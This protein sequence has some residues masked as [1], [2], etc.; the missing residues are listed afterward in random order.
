[1][2]DPAIA[3]SRSEGGGAIATVGSGRLLTP[4][5]LDRKNL[6]VFGR[7]WGQWYRA[8]RGIVGIDLR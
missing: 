4:E 7:T 5:E 2:E 6:A 3:E 1:M 8:T